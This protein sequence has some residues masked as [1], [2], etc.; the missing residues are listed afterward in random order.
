MEFLVGSVWAAGIAICVAAC[1]CGI[2]MG[3]A[4][5]GAMNGISRNPEASG[6]IQ[7][8]MLIGLALIESL[9]IYALVVA[10][11]LIFAHPA[12]PAILGALGGH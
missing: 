3:F 7:I 1:G 5:N 9:C 4:V 8:N 10:L 2:G 11:I 6:K 12:A